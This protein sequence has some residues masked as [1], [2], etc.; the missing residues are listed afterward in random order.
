[1]DPPFFYKWHI[2]CVRKLGPDL[3]MAEC[4]CDWNSDHQEEKRYALGLVDDHVRYF[5]NWKIYED[6]GLKILVKTRPAKTLNR[7][8]A[9]STGYAR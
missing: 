9:F 1:M 7:P 4:S 8:S 6:D 5:Y 3:W 2:I